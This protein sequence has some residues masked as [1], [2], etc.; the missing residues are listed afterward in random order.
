MSR[1]LILTP[2][3][4]GGLAA[5]HHMFNLGYHQTYN[6]KPF[7]DE[8]D[9]IDIPHILF[10]ALTMSGVDQIYSIGQLQYSNTS[11]L[12]KKV[13]QSSVKQW[14]EAYENT[15]PIFNAYKSGLKNEKYIDELNDIR[16]KL[17]HLIF[18]LKTNSSILSVG[19]YSTTIK[20]DGQLPVEL[21][22]PLKIFYNSIQ[23]KVVNLPVINFEVEKKDI[24]KL[25]DILLSKEFNNYKSAQSEIEQNLSLTSKTIKAIETTGK[26]LYKKNISQMYIRENLIRAIPLTSKVMELFLGKLPGIL[27]EYSSNLLS[28]FLK[29]NKSIPIYDCDKI[30]NDIKMA[31]LRAKVIKFIEINGVK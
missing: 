1:K 2:Y 23:T 12:A 24:Q 19:G 9:F 15:E 8:K 30:I 21:T 13:K 10:S 28:D 29:T 18:A 5:F 20:Y 22:I 6:L 27:A 14:S 7:S 3:E 31:S 26:E 16:Y 11:L 25:T 4:H 17:I